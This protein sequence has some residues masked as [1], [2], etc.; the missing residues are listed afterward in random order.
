MQTIRLSVRALLTLE[1]HMK[2]QTYINLASYAYL[3]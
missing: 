3:Q 2:S 1:L